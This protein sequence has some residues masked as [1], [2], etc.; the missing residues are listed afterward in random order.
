MLRLQA[1][2][3]RL[4]DFKDGDF[5][6][7]GYRYRRNVDPHLKWEDL[8]EA[9]EVETR[10][11]SYAP[12]GFW[13][14]TLCVPVQKV[15]QRYREMAIRNMAKIYREADRVLVLD[16]WIYAGSR[17]DHINERTMRILMSNWQRRLWTLQ[18][19]VLAKSLFFQFCDGP[20]HRD[21]L[22]SDVRLYVHFDR[23]F[24]HD[25]PS[26]SLV[27]LM[28][29]QD[30]VQGHDDTYS[31]FD[32]L[33]ISL[34]HRTTSRSSDETI[35]FATMLGLDTLQLQNIPSGEV[36]KR[37]AQFYRM[38]GKFRQHRIF[39]GSPR[40]PVKGF[41]W[42]PATF[43]NQTRYHAPSDYEAAGVQDSHLN[44]NGGLIVSYSGIHLG[45]VGSMLVPKLM[46]LFPSD[47][48]KGLLCGFRETEI[49][50][51]ISSWDSLKQYFLI[52][53]VSVESLFRTPYSQSIAILGTLE[54]NSNFDGFEI[55][56]V[57]RATL[58]GTDVQG[59]DDYWKG[60]YTNDEDYR[61][62]EG[63]LV[64]EGQRWCVV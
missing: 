25:I 8:Y 31:I 24:Y 52:S 5:S 17:E 11:P 32:M 35:C 44:L 60:E 9:V 64:E 51:G 7:G 28:S 59:Y 16:S 39:D 2:V 49:G 19:R 40:C 43:L 18:E 48:T 46:I 41:G 53:C 10:D 26:H 45:F 33:A 29:F 3:D 62:I 38:V 58:K 21:D 15:N 63:H 22:L 23:G 34:K 13:I 36:N 50:K 12:A 6:H 1:Y 42:A 37:M 27:G 55:K 20:H 47:H 54:D 30:I 14:D 57:C 4:Y 61:I 56:Y